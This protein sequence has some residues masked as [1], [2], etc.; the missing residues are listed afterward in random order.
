MRR[1]NIQCL[2]PSDWDALWGIEGRASKNT[3]FLTGEKEVIAIIEQGPVT[4][5]GLTN[6]SSFEQLSPGARFSKGP[7]TFRVR[8]HILW[9]K[10]V[11]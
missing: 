6:W 11:E 4:S 2:T 5:Y 3:R 7:V 10:P 1:T 8:G 9:L